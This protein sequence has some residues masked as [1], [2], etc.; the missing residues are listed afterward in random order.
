MAY[1]RNKRRMN[2]K[3]RLILTFFTILCLGV[4]IGLMFTPVFHVQEITC[5]GNTRIASQE[6]VATA[7]DAIGKNIFTIRLL[8]LSHR[9]EEIPMVEK[10][11]VR[12]VFPNKLKLHIVE[13]IPAGYMDTD[14]QLVVTDI[15]GKI[16]EIIA[17]D[18]VE[19]LRQA[20]IPK[21]LSK[22]PDKKDDTS[23]STSE[24]EKKTEEQ[25]N[26]AASEI[27]DPSSAELRSYSVPLVIGLT[28]H[29]PSV[30][31]KADSKE[32]EKFTKAFTLLRHLENAG[33]LERASFLNL[34]DMSD[35]TLVIENRLTIQFGAPENLEYRCAF[36]AK[37][38]NE[39]IS[40]TESAVMDYRGADIYVRPPE[41][42]KERMKPTQ[43]PAPTASS[44]NATEE[45]SAKTSAP[46]Q[47]PAT[48]TTLSEE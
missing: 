26:E 19:A 21:E 18:R 28:L 11:S 1:Y 39:R 4:G 45:S 27:I 14:N 12:R 16:L 5:E 24:T 31:K 20:Y 29:K 38:I 42:G 25:P 6:I 8:D 17:D 9:A 48:V 30:G 23:P 40:A 37:V 41:D 36:L 43:T 22:E 32:Q 15:E 3:L 46:S 47:K 44:G 13:C 34:T 7:Q 2:P 33:L 10:A 35:I